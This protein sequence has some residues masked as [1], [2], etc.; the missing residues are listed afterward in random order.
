[1]PVLLGTDVLADRSVRPAAF[2]AARGQVPA[3]GA[4]L[5]A[6]G[7]GVRMCLA[8]RRLFRQPL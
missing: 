6:G 1:M 4:G 3:C 8:D 7:D 2:T 5:P